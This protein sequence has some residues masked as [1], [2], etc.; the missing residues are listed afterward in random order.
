[1][2]DLFLN[3]L[4]ALLPTGNPYGW[5]PVSAPPV[6]MWW[7]GAGPRGIP[8]GPGGEDHIPPE[9]FHFVLLTGTRSEFGWSV[10]GSSYI[11]FSYNSLSDYF[12]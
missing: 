9:M 7:E 8:S 1:M 4:H 6:N 5:S 10:L 2:T 12:S 3:E 11:N